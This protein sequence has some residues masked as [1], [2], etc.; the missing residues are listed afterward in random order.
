MNA[1]L[2]RSLQSDWA[3]PL[4]II[5]VGGGAIALLRP[6]FLS[7]FN[8]EVLLLAISTNTMIALSQMIIIG[9]GQ[10]NLS[11]GAIGGLAAIAFAGMMQ[12]WG[13][14]PVLA[15]LAAL[16]I[17][18]LG[19][20]VN[21]YLVARTGISAFVITLA[22]LSIFKGINLG[23]TRAQ[24]FYG[25]PESVKAFGNTTFVYPLPWLI[26]PTIII[27]AL[28]WYALN[29]Q[30][31]GRYLLAVGGNSNAAELS[32]ISVFATVLRAHALS[33]FLAALAGV[34]LVA[35]LGIGQ[36]TI[37]DDWL[38]LSFA[39][40]VIGGA[41]L[42]GGHVSVAGTVLGVA[43]VAIIT[44]ALVL[45]EIDPFLVQVVLGALILWAVSANRVREVRMQKSLK[46]IA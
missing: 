34:M 20:I 39:A 4:L 5:V 15:V 21:G 44:Q 37:G 11:V 18:V 23:I 32:G 27:I 28:V 16:A 24:P 9:V 35:R 30:R 22:T 19:G 29:R 31:F 13:L 2:S 12:V 43:I 6:S 40:P 7:P 14:P 42:A 17:G 46:R 45:F 25:V 3:G 38:I 1:Q 36:P 26:L 8:I 33:G 41:A 10:M